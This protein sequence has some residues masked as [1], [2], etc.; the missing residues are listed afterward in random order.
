MKAV[1]A[2]D[3]SDPAETVGSWT[4]RPGQA[5][6]IG[7]D[8]SCQVRLEDRSV[9]RRHAVVELTG[10][11]VLVKDLGSRNGTFVS[12]KLVMKE[13]GELV[14]PGERLRVGDRELLV[15]VEG[16][17]PPTQKMKVPVVPDE[18][19]VLGMIGRGATG[20]VYAAR[21]RVLGRK[22]A[23]KVQHRRAGLGSKERFV[24]EAKILCRIDSPHVVAVHDI[25]EVASRMCLVME[26]VNGC[27]ARDRLRGGPLPIGEALDVGVDVAWAL[28]SSHRVGVVHRDVKPSNVVVTAS[29][30]AKL[31]D[32]GI[33]RVVGP[34]EEDLTPAG[35]GLGTLSY[36]SPEQV[37]EA[38]AVDARSDV[39]GLGATLYHL[40]S[41]KPPY[42][43]ERPEDLEAA[44]GTPPPDLAVL[45]PECPREVATFV[46][47][48]I[49]VDPDQRPH[50][51]A[52][53]AVVLE[54]L[55]RKHC[56]PRKNEDLEA[57][58]TEEAKLP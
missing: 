38:R 3:T 52:S 28:E 15:A 7:R 10:D 36:A 37:K 4:L 1:L 55:R 44:Y 9:S 13:D 42:L 25:R 51:A 27:S 40:V 26:L 34:C 20:N 22:V 47:R 18:F 39:Y 21:H 50:D 43:A 45:R 14:G 32:F 24:R 6:V 58:Q 8:A 30:E 48:M 12:G 46:H 35:E 17:E 54:R 29:G 56:G 33:A 16:V 49:H 53:C 2:L 31:T 19:E 41:G 57:T 11:G 5:F 23:I